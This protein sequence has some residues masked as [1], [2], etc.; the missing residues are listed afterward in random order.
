[1]MQ[2]N[3]LET[4]LEQLLK[5]GTIL[6]SVVI[7]VGILADML[8]A[9]SLRIDLVTVGI[10]GFIVLPVVRILVMLCHYVK[11]NDIP[12]VRVVALVLALVIAGVV[13]GIVW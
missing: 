6:C 13:L 9:Q 8:I 12:M 2:S 7:A 5:Y 10:I 1:M 4:R 11:A 3:F